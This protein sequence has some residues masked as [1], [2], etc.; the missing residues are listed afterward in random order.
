MAKESLL[1]QISFKNLFSVIN[2]IL[3][4][5]FSV[6]LIGAVLLF[7]SFSRHHD[8][9]YA[10]YSALFHS[11]SGFCNAG[12]SLYRLSLMGFSGSIFFNIVMAGLIISG[13]LGFPVLY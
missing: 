4:I 10:L 12:F 9:G 2:H 7:F 13:G 3:V 11:I 6:E 1:G 8:T 5:T